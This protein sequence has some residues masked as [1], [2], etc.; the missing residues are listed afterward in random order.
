LS[1]KVLA[2]KEKDAILRFIGTLL[3]DF[4]V[5]LQFLHHF[6]QDLPWFH[7][8]STSFSTNSES[9]SVSSFAA[10]FS[11][12][13]ERSFK[14]AFLILVLSEGLIKMGAPDFSRG[15]AH[16]QEVNRN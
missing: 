10:L 3:S 14:M 6:L 15:V 7:I 13:F 11:S 8:L 12:C 1:L 5:K 4:S 2:L 9:S 16:R